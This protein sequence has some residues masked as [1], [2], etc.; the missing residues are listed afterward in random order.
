MANVIDRIRVSAQEGFNHLLDL[1]GEEV[2][3]WSGANSVLLYA[4]VDKPLQIL[5]N[6]A[7]EVGRSDVTFQFLKSDL[8]ILGTNIDKIEWE[9]REYGLTN[10]LA[11]NKDENLEIYAV[12]GRYVW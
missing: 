7:G 10:S 2:R 12:I 4:L 3:V 8:G 5:D 11:L 1:F 6:N 9:G